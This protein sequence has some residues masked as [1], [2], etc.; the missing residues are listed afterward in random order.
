MKPTLTSVLPFLACIGSSAATL[1]ARDIHLKHK[2]FGL[3]TAAVDDLDL[4]GNAT[5]EQNVDHSDPSM[6]TFEQRYWWDGSHYKKGGPVFVFNPG[7]SSADGM[8]GYTRNTTIP[9]RY[10]QEF[11]GA[12]IVIE[13]RCLVRTEWIKQQPKSKFHPMPFSLF[14]YLYPYNHKLFQPLLQNPSCSTRDH[15][16]LP[17][18]C[19]MV[20]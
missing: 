16:L 17:M 3:K 9:G 12:V 2:R 15:P 18:P 20:C 5:F 1:S 19:L 14:L 10:A 13:R 8:I 4:V 6:G 7:E 11:S